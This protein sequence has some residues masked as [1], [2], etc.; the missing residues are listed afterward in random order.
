MIM[1]FADENGK[2]NLDEVKNFVSNNI[3]GKKD[4]ELIKSRMI[5]DAQRVRFLAKLRVE[6]DVRSGLGMFSLPDSRLS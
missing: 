6:I 1:R 5:N 2:V 3:P 4:W